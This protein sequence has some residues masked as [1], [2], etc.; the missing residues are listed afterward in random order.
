MSL[1]RQSD[2]GIA[3]SWAGWPNATSELVPYLVLR[4]TVCGNLNPTTGYV[5]NVKELDHVLRDCVARGWIADQ[6]WRGADPATLLRDAWIDCL[7]RMPNETRLHQLTLC[8]TPFLSY[9]I[10]S[11]DESMVSISQQF[12]FSASHRLHCRELSDEQNRELFGKCNNPHGHGHN[13]VLEL[14]WKCENSDQPPL[15]WNLG[16]IEAIVK[17]LVI[18]RV[19]H[20]YLNEEVAAFADLNPSVENIAITIWGWLEGQFDSIELGNVRVYE[21]PK[22]WADYAGR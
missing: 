8:I 3:N 17:E 18:D 10:A 5:C 20:K 2:R 21:T 11:G 19:D 9:T 7:P 14:T 16:K 4:C 15:D 13:Y 22:T 6:Q 1:A 12:E